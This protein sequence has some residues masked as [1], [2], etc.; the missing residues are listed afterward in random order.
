MGLPVIIIGAGG[1]AKVLLSI[2]DSMN[3]NIIGITDTDK[4]LI[5]EKMHG[6]SIIGDDQ[7]VFNYNP[8]A[9]MLVNGV[10][11]TKT[12]EKRKSIY[13][14]FKS[15]SYNFLTL[16]HPSTTVSYDVTIGEGVQAITGAIIHPYCRIGENTV[17][18]GGSF[19]GHDCKIGKHVF[20][21][22]GVTICGGG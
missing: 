18:G 6:L 14:L 12:T 7:V 19:I 20:I 9:I 2:L 13:N 15:K 8:E 11:S 17:I 10:G 5:G 16:I 4:K 3:L 22:P 21:A 1:H